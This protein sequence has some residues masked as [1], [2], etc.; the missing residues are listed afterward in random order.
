MKDYAKEARIAIRLLTEH[1]HPRRYI[2]RLT[3]ENCG[4]CI[5]N[6]YHPKGEKNTDINYAG[7][8]R[9]YIQAGKFIPVN[10]FMSFLGELASDNRAYA[11]SLRDDIKHYGIHAYGKG[12][13][14]FKQ[15]VNNVLGIYD[16]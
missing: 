1:C 11:D 14:N 7:W 13:E 4:A 9:I 2:D 3:H 8:A 15:V 12:S 16:A 5:L 6:G 10:L